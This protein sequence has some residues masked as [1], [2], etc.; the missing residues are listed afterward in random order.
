M[1]LFSNVLAERFKWFWVLFTSL[2]MAVYADQPSNHTAHNKPELT[3]GLYPL[4]SQTML[5]F[6][7]QPLADFLQHSEARPVTIKYANS[8]QLFLK[9]CLAASH[10]VIV[11]PAHI[12]ALLTRHNLYQPLLILDF[13]L[14]AF[15]VSLNTG[16]IDKPHQLA[17]KTLA[18]ANPIALVTMAGLY[19]LKQQNIAI[20]KINIQKK[21]THDRALYSLLSG[22]ADAALISNSFYLELPTRTAKKLRAIHQSQPLTSDIIMVKRES[23]YADSIRNNFATSSEGAVYLTRW[24]SAFKLNPINAEQL[25]QKN[26]KY[27]LLLEAQ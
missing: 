26:N 21:S 22:H 13:D 17:S 2:A 11:A 10:D 23:K 18:V 20:E 25:L 8:Y 6:R 27:S 24:K 14:R 9:Q 16:S 5:Q 19:G 12:A 3:L 1:L 15:I 7:H 4:L